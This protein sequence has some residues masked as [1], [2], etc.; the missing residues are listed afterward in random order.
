MLSSD[1]ASALF[2]GT[3]TPYG[4]SQNV[5]VAW[6]FKQRTELFITKMQISQP[7]QNCNFEFSI[8][9]NIKTLQK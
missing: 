2:F 4:L 5:V 1:D 6:C 3:D 7:L 8:P 9:I